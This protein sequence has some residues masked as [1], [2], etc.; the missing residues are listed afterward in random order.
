MFPA[1]WVCVL[2]WEYAPAVWGL[3]YPQR[4][5]LNFGHDV[6]TLKFFTLCGLQ[7]GYEP[8]CVNMTRPLTFWYSKQLPIFENAEDLPNTK[9]DVTRMPAGADNPPSLKVRY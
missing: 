5:K 1:L 7:E 2:A 9:I 3:A 6:D 8:F 4:V